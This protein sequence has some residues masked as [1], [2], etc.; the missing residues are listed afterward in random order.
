MHPVE[1]YWDEKNY[2]Y[3]TVLPEVEKKEF[4][5]ID[6]PE[7]IHADIRDKPSSL[8]Q[9]IRKIV[10]GELRDSSGDGD[11]GGRIVA[12]DRDISGSLFEVWQKYV[13]VLSLEEQQLILQASEEGIQEENIK[14][15]FNMTSEEM[16]IFPVFLS[17]TLCPT[18]WT[19]L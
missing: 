13:D 5:D 12:K 4:C 11:S 1:V 8:E 10:Y 14:A 9:A 2:R 3:I 15:M 17:K 6:N 7:F 19:A 16:Q 18:H